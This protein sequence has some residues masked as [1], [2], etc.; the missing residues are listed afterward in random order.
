MALDYWILLGAICAPW[1]LI[2]L[3]FAIA[4]LFHR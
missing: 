3:F 2:T 4:G 1:A